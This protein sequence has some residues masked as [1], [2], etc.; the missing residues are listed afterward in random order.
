VTHDQ[1]EAMAAADLIVVMNKGGI[2]QI[3][4]PRDIYEFPKSVFV[5]RFI[6]GNNVIT[7]RPVSSDRLSLNGA[8]LFC[9]DFAKLDPR[10]ATGAISIRTE[11][12][13]ILKEPG[14]RKE[15]TARGR[16]RRKVYAGGRHDYCVALDCGQDVRIL[17]PLSCDAK[18]DE[19][20]WV[21]FP[22]EHCL[23]VKN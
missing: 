10:D 4:S 11:H 12:A 15:N 13:S 8:D 21:F 19:V 14:P 3:G 20:V 16:V 2:E 6:G 23:A 17:A 9:N 5:A 1:S 18:M 7:G 22:R